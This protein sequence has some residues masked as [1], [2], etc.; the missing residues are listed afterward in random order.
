MAGGGT[1]TTANVLASATSGNLAGTSSVATASNTV[2]LV[3]GDVIRV[4]YP[5]PARALSTS[6]MATFTISKVGKPNL[7]SVDVTP[8]VNINTQD[9]EAIEALTATT[10]FGSTN[11]GIPVLN[12]TKNTNLGIIQ[13]ISDSASGTSFKA[14]KDCE[15]KINASATAA[16][17]TSTYYVTRNS[18]TLTT[19]ATNGVVASSDI[20]NL[21][22]SSLS[23][24]LKLIAGD[25]IRLHR[26]S[27]NVTGFSQVSVTATALNSST[28]SPT[29]QVSS[30]TMSFVF[31]S[32]AITTSDPIGT[33]NTYTY[34][35]NTNTATI[36]T[37]APTQSTSSMN[38]N[39]VQVFARAYNAASTAASPARVEIFI[40]TGLKSKQVEA[41]GAL[42]KSTPFHYDMMQTSSTQE[43]GTLLTYN[44]VTGV[45]VIDG[46]FANPQ[47]GSATTARILGYSS[48]PNASYSSGY[49]VFNASKSPSLVTIPNL[50]QRVAYLKDVKTGGATAGGASTAGVYQTRVLN[51]LEDTTGIVKSLASNQFTLP[52]GK[53]LIEASAP[54][55]AGNT[56][57]LRLRNITDST[58]PIMGTK[59]FNTAASAS[60][61]TS[62]LGGVITITS[63]KV[64]EIQQ[65]IQTANGEGLGISN[66]SGGDDNV[67]AQVKIT[68]IL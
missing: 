34:A 6:T 11:T 21:Y 10:T 58:S 5:V 52:S 62:V 26:V 15:I 28:A 31:K 40:G 37:T 18:T 48:V 63:D 59:E 8:F 68:K 45:L 22:Y 60:Q 17:S 14:L 66:V 43:S 53:Y 24:S 57:K 47:N 65:Y 42:A 1:Q 33:F 19:G 20:S 38:T 36:A 12:I 16:T 61:T 44:E 9:V 7:T 32:T 35:I 55:F 3:K 23:T 4:V 30:D 50:V 46:G 41:Y 51:T 2:Q 13:V 25:V 27:A 29:Q 49:F 39:G 64:F 67:F 56:H 54:C